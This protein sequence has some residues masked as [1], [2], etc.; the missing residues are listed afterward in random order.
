MSASAGT[1]QLPIA[2]RY[3]VLELLARANHAFDDLD[4]PAFA[5]CFTPAGVLES[6]RGRHV[7][8]GQLAAYVD[9]SAQRPPHIHF[10]TNTVIRTDEGG[11]SRLVVRSNFLYVEQSR[12]R[13]I[14]DSLAGTY[15]DSLR[16]H[17][18]AWLIEHRVARAA[19]APRTI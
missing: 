4:G 17:G 8:S 14:T 15:L 7:G 2:E 6:G 19:Q 18:G 9:S 11:G 5:A 1:P 3:A 13:E 10:T 12:P 16:R